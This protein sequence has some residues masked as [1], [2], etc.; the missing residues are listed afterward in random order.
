M[1]YCHKPDSSAALEEIP[2]WFAKSLCVGDFFEKRVCVYSGGKFCRALRR[3]LML[4]PKAKRLTVRA[5]EN[6]GSVGYFYLT[7][8]TFSYKMKIL[9]DKRN[10]FLMDFGT[11]GIC[12][13][14]NS[15]SVIE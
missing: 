12:Q 6:V 11:E 15:R 9:E 14:I 7:D 13:W 4:S 1:I 2:L 8:G 3:T 10:A 5:V